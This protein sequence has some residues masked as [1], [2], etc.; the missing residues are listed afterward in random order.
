[1]RIFH[2]DRQLGIPMYED[3]RAERSAAERVRRRARW[4]CVV[5]RKNITKMWMRMAMEWLKM[6]I[7]TMH[8]EP[9]TY[10]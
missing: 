8:Q 2:S 1:M 10:L 5:R 9:T 3:E 4:R 7:G 6:T